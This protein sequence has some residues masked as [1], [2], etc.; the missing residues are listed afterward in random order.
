LTQILLAGSQSNTWNTIGLKR[1]KKK[2]S[3]DQDLNFHFFLAET[4]H[5]TIGEILQMPVEEFNLWVAYFSNKADQQQ[6]EL[7]KQKMQGKRR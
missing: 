1:L 5:K 2:V 6:K 7:N 3:S 4:L